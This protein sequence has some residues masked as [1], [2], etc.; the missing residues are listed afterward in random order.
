MKRNPVPG[1]A[2]CLS[3]GGFRAALFHLGAVRRLNEL[4]ILSQVKAISSVSG[5]SILAAHLATTIKPWP[6]PG[7]VL[8][9]W[10][11]DVAQPFRNFVSKN[12][13][14]R[15]LLAR[16]VNPRYWRPGGAAIALAQAYEDRLS[17]MKLRDLPDRPDFTFCSTDLSH[18]V[19]WIFSKDRVGSY[20]AG[21]K[22]PV[23]VDLRVATAVAASSCFPPFFGP[24][25]AGFRPEEL[26]GG[27]S[28]DGREDSVG[29]LR[30]SDGGLYDNLGL[31]PVWKKYQTI[32]V[33]D[34]GA[35]FRHVAP[36]GLGRM[37]WRY[38]QVQERQ[39][40]ALRRR[41]FHDQRDIG[42]FDG[43]YWDIGDSVAAPTAYK[44][45]TVAGI[46]SRV[47]TDMDAFSEAEQAVLE[48]HGYGVADDQIRREAGHLLPNPAAPL[49][50]PHPHAIDRFVEAQMVKSHK[51]RIPFGRL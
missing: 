28:G 6:K 11:K 10:E 35:P 15:P 33:S 44:K 8:E 16:W 39:G 51:R 20:Q 32:L 3:G 45:A 37:L 17:G 27:E 18:G 40:L 34:G 5:G 42:R 47:R 48:N 26:K 1:I 24:L 30:L 36:F 25:P 46:I 19:N 29:R 7:D 13:R 12:L 9:S 14:T 23:P 22:S 38:V 31:E 43:S 49:Q 4:G 21:Y 2:L 41:S 50:V